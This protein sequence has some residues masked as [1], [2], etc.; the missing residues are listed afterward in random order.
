M[1]DDRLLT[2]REAW[3]YLKVCPRKLDKLIAK[4]EIKIIKDGPHKQSMVRIRM[5]ELI[6]YLERHT[7]HVRTA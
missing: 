3:E 1:K 6:K 4:G 5:V 7:I 2:K